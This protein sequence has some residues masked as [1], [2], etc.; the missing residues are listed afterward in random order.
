MCEDGQEAS[1]DGAPWRRGCSPF[2]EHL[3]CQVSCSH[4]EMAVSLTFGGEN[5]DSE[6][7]GS[8]GGPGLCSACGSHGTTQKHRGVFLFSC[9]TV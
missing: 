8:R 7:R 9:V 6:K 5:Q 2:P 4:Q 1:E 3:L